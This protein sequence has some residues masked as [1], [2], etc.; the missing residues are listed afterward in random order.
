MNSLF[1]FLEKSFFLENSQKLPTAF[2]LSIMALHQTKV[3]YRLLF[4]PLSVCIS[5]D[6][7]R[8]CFRNP[9]DSFE[10]IS[11]MIG[12]ELY[13]SSNSDLCGFCS[14]LQIAITVVFVPTSVV[15]RE[16]AFCKP[17]EGRSAGAWSAVSVRGQQ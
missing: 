14:Y 11:S 8:I 10:R 17:A 13:T 15:C 4:A 7:V 2:S 3:S 1:R 6:E 5:P 16:I 9:S 12:S